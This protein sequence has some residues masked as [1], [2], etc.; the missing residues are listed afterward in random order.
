MRLLPLAVRAARAQWTALVG[1]GL[2][3]A[4]TAFLVGAGPRWAVAT[5]DR[6]VRDAVTGAPAG[7]ADLVV[8]VLSRAVGPAQSQFRGKGPV[9][10]VDGLA[11]LSGYWRQDIPRPLRDTIGASDHFAGTDFIAVPGHAANRPTVRMSI[12]I[13]A[14]A[15]GHLRYVSGRAPGPPEQKGTGLRLEAALPDRAAR[16][17]GFTTGDVIPIKSQPGLTVRISGLF[18]P[19]DPGSGY[20]AAHHRF[21]DAELEQTTSGDT[22]V[23]GTALLSPAGYH[24]LCASTQLNVGVTWTYTPAAARITAGRAH[25]LAQG[26]HQA[27]ESIAN[28]TVDGQYVTLTSRLDHVLDDFT[29]RLTATRTLLSLALAGLFAAALGVLALTAR[30]VPARMR[31]ALSTQAARGASRTQLAVITVMVVGSVTLPAA[32]IGLV[33]AALLVDGPAQGISAVSAAAVVATV[34]ALSAV[35][36]ARGRNTPVPGGSSARRAVAEGTVVLVAVGATYLLR[37]RGMPTGGLDPLISA[38]PALLAIAAGLLALRTC[39]ALLRLICRALARGRSAVGFIG[40]AQASRQRATAMLPVVLLVLTFA[41]IGFTATVEASLGRAQRLA[42]WQSVG[43]DA[44]VDT[45]VMDAATIDRVRRSPG[46]RT[47]VPAEVIDGA[48]LFSREYTVGDVTLVAV[49]LGAYRQA[50]AGTSLRIPAPRA[51]AGAFPVLFSPAAAAGAKGGGLSLTTDAGLRLELRDA[52]VI[53]R[54]PGQA[55][56]ARFVV[57]PYA[58]VFKSTAGQVPG[59]LFIRGDHLDVAALRRAAQARDLGQFGAG[60]VTT[61]RNEHDAITGGRLGHMMTAGF[62]ACGLFAAGYGLLALLLL[63]LSEVRRRGSVVSYLRALGL[64]RR[65]ARRLA[66]VEVVPAL[67]A[68]AVAGWALGAVLPSVVGPALDLRAYTGGLPIA[69]YLPD[70]SSVAVLG[71]GLVIMPVMTVLSDIAAGARGR[72]AETLRIGGA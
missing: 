46:V 39:S 36:A 24:G 25:T 67:V 43:G 70:L 65:E 22:I 48:H 71:G 7:S 5:Y 40:F 49:D 28:G 33:T 51:E 6:A 53:S 61:Y 50:M 35:T 9:G 62:R 58:P 2:L 21:E 56:D 15:S 47:A 41:V 1:L 3:M 13:S 59:S 64:S 60:G 29:R 42:T 31:V 34:I 20:W 19:T 26:V 4:V 55:A 57:V 8:S 27:A 54:F 44:R 17:M 37:L 23:L 63:L 68:A 11:T 66:L 14:T 30:L 69:H 12:G 18:T 52:G 16:Q 32:I 10:S 38:V 45:Q 72:P